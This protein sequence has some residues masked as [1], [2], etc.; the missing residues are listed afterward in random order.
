MSSSSSPETHPATSSA[1]TTSSEPPRIKVVDMKID[2]ESA[3]L[4]CMVSFLNI[5]QKRG[6]FQLDEASKIYECMMM[7]THAPSK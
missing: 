2:S 1:E 4:N 7:F 6:C 5:A 3:A